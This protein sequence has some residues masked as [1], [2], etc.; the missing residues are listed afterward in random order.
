ME[1]REQ[2]REKEQSG[3]SVT[4]KARD[5]CSYV[6]AVTQKSPKQFRFSYVGRLQ[7]LALS[8]IEV[9]IRANDLNAEGG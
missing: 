5:L 9:I 2:S 8:I 4:T 6:M 3:F 7:N 1:K